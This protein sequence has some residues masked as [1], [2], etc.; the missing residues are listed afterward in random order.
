MTMIKKLL[1]PHV[2]IP[3]LLVG[4]LVAAL[5]SL[6]NIGKVI[7]LMV[8]FPPIDLLLFLALM[9]AYEVVRGVQWIVLLRALRLKSPLRTELFAFSVSEVTKAL[10]IGN[11]VQNYLLQESEQREDFGRTSAAT[12]LII[13]LEVGVSLLGVF[14]FGDGSWT[15]P[16][17]I[18]IVVGVAVAVAVV[19]LGMRFSQR[20]DPPQ[21][22]QKRKFLRT[23]LAKLHSFA[24]GV[25][26]LLHPRTLALATGL[27]AL[28]LVIAALGLF[29]IALGLHIQVSFTQTLSVYLLSLAISLIFPLPV[30]IGVL[31]ISMLGAFAA[32]GVNRNA[33]LGASLLNRIL[34]IGASMA[35]AV[36]ALAILNRELRAALRS[37]KKRRAE[38]GQ[39][40][41]RGQDQREHHTAEREQP[42]PQPKPQPAPPPQWRPH[43]R[44]HW[45]PRAYPAPALAHT[46]AP[47]ASPVSFS[48]MANR[49]AALAL[50][51]LGLVV[52]IDLA[53]VIRQIAR[54]IIRR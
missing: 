5:L 17:R 48:Q 32:V 6:T 36:V 30:D 43:W 28:Y 21:W 29:V 42:Q 40:E 33:G 1:R 15:V 4:G 7:A 50:V 24:E 31:E 13:L 8:A 20:H 10:P 45:Q 46:H 2:V 54:P 37:G 25:R 27:S 12:T 39:Q 51:G 49:R 22:A 26:D 23:A 11:Y 44:P 38:Q 35:L 34:S 53:L 3:L 47:D 19:W 9:V 52:L 18:I 41:Q 16:L 14:I